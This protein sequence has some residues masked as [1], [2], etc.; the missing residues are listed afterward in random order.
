MS[1]TRMKPPP[2][3]PK[4]RAAI[5]SGAD[6]HPSLELCLTDF[7]SVSRCFSDGD[8]GTEA[9]TGPICFNYN[10]LSASDKHTHTDKGAKSFPQADRSE[11]PGQSGEGGEEEGLGDKS[12]A[13]SVQVNFWTMIT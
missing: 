1:F 13:I 7:G 3:Q 8:S 6:S 11:A 12:K 2:S 9:P 10:S 4:S 5:K